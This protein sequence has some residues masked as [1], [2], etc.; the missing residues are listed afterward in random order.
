MKTRDERVAAIAY[1]RFLARGGEHGHDVEDWLA[2]EAEVA[3]EVYEVVVVEPGPNVIEVLRVLRDVSGRGLPDL[4]AAIETTPFV[5]MRG[6]LVDG[7]RTREAV[8]SVHGRIE[9]RPA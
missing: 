7:Q 6:S 8:E 2:A 3:N 9:L 1:R 4:K 5:L